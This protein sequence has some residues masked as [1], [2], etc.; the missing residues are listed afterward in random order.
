MKQ[1]LILFILTPCLLVSCIPNTL[2]SSMRPYRL[3]VDP[4][5]AKAGTTIY[6]NDQAAVGL[7]GI[8]LGGLSEAQRQ[9]AKIGERH[10]SSNV[11]DVFISGAEAPSGW[12]ID[13]V[14]K[15]GIREIIDITGSRPDISF[16]SY[17]DLIFSIRIPAG[18]EPGIY[19]A[20]A[21]VSTLRGQTK[22]LPMSIEILAP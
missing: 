12:V 15:Q 5:Q 11:S 22:V 4:I 1:F 17:I 20:E 10:I 16:S 9:A 13:L 7:F 21:R 19:P 6:V 3:Y 8:N 2:G 14:S 18:V